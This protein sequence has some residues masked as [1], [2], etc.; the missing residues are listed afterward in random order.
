MVVGKQFDAIDKDGDG[1]ITLAE[2]ISAL[3]LSGLASASLKKSFDS[4]RGKGIF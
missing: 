1:H 2:L 4:V 3:H